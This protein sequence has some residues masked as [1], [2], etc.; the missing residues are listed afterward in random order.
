MVVALVNAGAD[1]NIATDDRCT[2]LFVAVRHSHHAVVEALA[3]AG[4]EVNLVG[5]RVCFIGFGVKS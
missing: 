1:V 5:V 4:A 3:G 2:P